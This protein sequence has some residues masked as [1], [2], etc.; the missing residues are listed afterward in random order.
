M[1]QQQQQQQQQLQQ[2]Q[3]YCQ[4]SNDW[5][6]NQTSFWLNKWLE[7]P[8]SA[9]QIRA[10]LSNSTDALQVG[11]NIGFGSKRDSSNSNRHQ[12]HGSKM[13]QNSAANNYW[14]VW[15]RPSSRGA[16]NGNGRNTT[17]HSSRT[18]RRH[19]LQQLQNPSKLMMQG[20]SGPPGP[21]VSLAIGTRLVAV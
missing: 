16:D 11:N 8:N 17:Q 13:T 12:H 9:N 20:E 2:Q 3:Q 4:C 6:E 21:K 19:S 14:N 15:S 7:S 10:L 18:S 5:L 1:V